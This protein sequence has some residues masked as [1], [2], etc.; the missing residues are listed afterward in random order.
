MTNTTET[1]NNWT[2]ETLRLMEEMFNLVAAR[3]TT[4][5]SFV[6]NLM[7]AGQRA[8]DADRRV[9][10]AFGR[11]VACKLAAEVAA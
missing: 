7:A 11:F 3:S 6:Q 4:P 2:P 8:M 9:G 10:Q 5:E 1:P